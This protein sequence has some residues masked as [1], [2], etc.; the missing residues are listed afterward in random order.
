MSDVTAPSPTN[1]DRA[2]DTGTE[3]TADAEKRCGA[4]GHP[5]DGHDGISARYCAAT[6]ASGATR[7]CV[8]GLGA[9]TPKPN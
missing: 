4:C 6:I 8:C 5:L 3:T 7:G 2:A 1:T 9:A